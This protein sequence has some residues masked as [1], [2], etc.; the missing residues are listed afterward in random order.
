MTPQ[1]KGKV[2]IVSAD[3]MPQRRRESGAGAKTGKMNHASEDDRSQNNSAKR[4]DNSK[5]Y[6]SKSK[7]SKTD[8]SVARAN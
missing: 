7:S 3:D 8:A 5:A 1:T 4:K 6:A 2:L